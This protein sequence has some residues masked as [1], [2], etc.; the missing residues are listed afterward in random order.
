MYVSQIEQTHTITEQQRTMQ[1]N[2]AEF[3]ELIAT[4]SKYPSCHLVVQPL[5]H[6][7]HHHHQRRFNTKIQKTQSVTCSNIDKRHQYLFGGGVRSTARICVMLCNAQFSSRSLY[8]ICRN[9]PKVG[10]LRVFVCVKEKKTICCLPIMDR[11]QI[12]F[13][14]A[15]KKI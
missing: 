15:T 9:F 2:A 7:H 10:K 12:L 11:Y 4:R 5:F 6:H 13:Y 1:S 8:R 14:R 3:D